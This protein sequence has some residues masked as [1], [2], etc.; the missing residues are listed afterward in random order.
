MSFNFRLNRVWNVLNK[1][2]V[3]DVSDPMFR[4]SDPIFDTD[5]TVLLALGI[6]APESR[7]AS[8]KYFCI[9]QLIRLFID[10]DFT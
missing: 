2:G 10:V 9:D 8:F 5:T 3:T 6:M 1:D 7:G 4:K